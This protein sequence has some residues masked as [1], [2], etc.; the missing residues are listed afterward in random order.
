MVHRVRVY[1]NCSPKQTK[2]PKLNESRYCPNCGYE[3][4]KLDYYS[5]QKW[6]KNKKFECVYLT[7]IK[8]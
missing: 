8:K 7:L 6:M 3:M 1:G 4:K 5:A 2:I